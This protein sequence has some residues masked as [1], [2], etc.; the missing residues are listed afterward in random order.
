MGPEAGFLEITRK[1]GVFDLGRAQPLV[2]PHAEGDRQLVQ[3][4]AE[5][6]GHGSFHFQN[7]ASPQ[8]ETGYLDTFHAHFTSM[9]HFHY[10]GQKLHCESVDLATVAQLHGTPTY[11]YSA[12]TIEDNYR[13]LAASLGGLDVQICYAMKA[14]SN[15]AV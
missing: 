2:A 13:R 12:Q 15:L 5:L 6:I 7:S 1:L 4:A 8:G 3:Q 14:N 11:V 10:K 9:H